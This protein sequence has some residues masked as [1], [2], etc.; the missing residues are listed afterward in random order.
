MNQT[1][2]A[3]Q[4]NQS[5]TS[6]NIVDRLSQSVIRQIQEE[7]QTSKILNDSDPLLR[8]QE[9]LLVIEELHLRSEFIWREIRYVLSLR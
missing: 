5:V 2:G 8:M 6:V 7:S 1:S 3:N 9:N 4:M